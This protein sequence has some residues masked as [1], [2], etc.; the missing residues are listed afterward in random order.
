MH[1]CMYICIRVYIHECIYIHIYMYT[2]IYMH[3]YVPITRM[4]VCVIS[5]P[6]KNGLIALCLSMNGA[7]PYFLLLPGSKLSITEITE[8]TYLVHWRLAVNLNIKVSKILYRWILSLNQFF[9]CETQYLQFTTRVFGHSAIT[10]FLGG[11]AK[12]THLTMYIKRD[13]AQSSY[14]YTMHLGLVLRVTHT[15]T[16]KHRHTL[17]HTILR[18]TRARSQIRQRVCLCVV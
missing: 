6:P 7:I 12:A 13:S 17:A 8:Y 2:Y 18:Y 9:F 14:M 1:I 5:H 10:P 3:T 11:C 16:H 4:C 15:D